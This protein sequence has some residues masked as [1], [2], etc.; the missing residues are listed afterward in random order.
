[1]NHASLDKILKAEVF[2]HANG[3][4]RATHLILDYVPISKS[5]LVPKCVIKARDPQLQ[6]TSIATPGFLISSPIPKGT[7]TTEPIFE[8]IPKVTLPIQ[9][10]IGVAAS[11]RT[12]NTEEEEVVEVLDSEDGFEFF[13]QALS[14]ATST[15]DLGHPFSPILDE[16]GIQC[17][18]KSSLMDLIKS[19]PGRDVL[20]KAA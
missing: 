10:A 14:L 17:R 12:T 13:N 20:G 15:P 4:L 6:Q 5:F 2:V 3:Q 1:M 11:S 16:M 8:G 18:P 19:Q 9:Q 7:L